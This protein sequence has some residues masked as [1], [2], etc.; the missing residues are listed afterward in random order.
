M[1]RLQNRNLKKYF[2]GGN[3]RLLNIE[4]TIFKYAK[5]YIKNNSKYNPNIYKSTPQAEDKFP[6]IIIK[7]SDNYFY[8][9]C[10]DKEDQKFKISYEIE[11]YT[12]NINDKSNIIAKEIVT[13]ELINLVNDVFD[14]HFGFNRKEN[15]NIPN[16]DKNIDR[17][18]LRYE[19]IVDSKNIIYRR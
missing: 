9:E 18:H 19:A 17:Q 1:K 4:D 11:I 3:I 5:E 2:W 15:L 10:L 7:E 13:K 8:E 14:V 6:L 16:I 12:F